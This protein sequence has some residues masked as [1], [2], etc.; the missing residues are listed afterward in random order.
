MKLKN[1]YFLLRHGENN[2]QAEKP[3]IVYFWPENNP[4]CRLTEK[5]EE[6][7][8]EV[9][10]KI[11]REKIN[12]IYSSDIVRTK[13]SAE[14][15]AGEINK[16]I[17][18]DQRL[19]DTNWGKFGGGPK[20]KAYIFFQE[21]NS[22]E[23][24]FKKAPEGGESWS[25]CQKRVLDFLKEVERKYQNKNIL[26]VSHGDPLWLLEGV[27]KKTSVKEIMKELTEP[28]NAKQKY[29]KVGDVREL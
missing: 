29:M 22:L 25:D 6:Q 16:K 7:I 5:G 26:I 19:R 9:V 1:T 27:V 28:T 12:L 21:A 15:V 3:G 23:E 18:F 10:E 11:K 20:E 2:C 4:P 24:K 8:R 14:I 17:I 13:Q